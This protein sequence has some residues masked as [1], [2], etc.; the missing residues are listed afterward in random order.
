MAVAAVSIVG[1]LI[2]LDFAL[3]EPLIYC[4]QEAGPSTVAAVGRLADRD[5]HTGVVVLWIA[6]LFISSRCFRSRMEPASSSDA[7]TAWSGSSSFGEPCERSA[8]HATR[9][10]R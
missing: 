10:I 9:Y 8:A 6:T 4:A 2:W 1:H 3:N 5:A 7:S